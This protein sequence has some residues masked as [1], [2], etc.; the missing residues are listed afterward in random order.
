MKNFKRVIIVF[1]A[2]FIIMLSL[3]SFSVFAADADM[4]YGRTKL[5]GDL[6]YIYDELA[7]GCESAKSEIQINLNGRNVELNQDLLTKICTLVYSDYPE[8]FWFNGGY[9]AS[10]NGTVLTIMPTYTIT[11]SALTSAKSA[12]TAKVNELTN[13]LSGKSDYEK[14]KILHDRLIDTATFTSTSNDQNAYGALVEGKA[15]C[16]GYARAYQHLMNK[17]G[18]P[19]WFVRGTSINP[20]TN[21]PIAHAWNIAKINGN[22]YYTDVTWDDQNQYTF[23]EYFNITTARMAESHTL[24]SLY[25]QLVPNA[26]ATAANYYIKEGREFIT[27]D[28]NKFVNLLKQDNNKTQIYINGNV[29]SFLSSINLENLGT[30]LGA[31]GTY[32]ISCIPYQLNHAVILSVVIISGDHTHKATAVPQ[33]NANCLTNGKKAHFTCECGLK[34]LDNACT[35]QT[36]DS[37]LTIPAIPHT[38]LAYKNDA[39]GHWKECTVCGIEIA[40]TRGAHFDQN[41]DN[42]CDTCIYAVP[43]ADANGNI[44]MGGNNLNNNNS[45]STAASDNTNSQSQAADTTNNIDAAENAQVSTSQSDNFTSE[46]ISN[47]DEHY[48]YVGANVNNTVLK[49]IIICVISAAII[50]AGVAVTIVLIIKKKT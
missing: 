26:T 35:N 34:F 36:T 41:N 32:Y 44:V 24:E 27:Y 28:Q 14:S 43:V 45:S 20:T 16:N 11:G 21:T 50:T 9:S 5:S 12:Y 2:F 29:N 42:K 19:T 47:N 46:P 31:S 8:Y 33:A 30:A 37:E 48:L 10:F 22:W 6:Q 49:W 1:L 3:P 15:V 25:A 13:G 38:V 39:T 4:R 23:Y 40:N 17:V 18:V 7:K